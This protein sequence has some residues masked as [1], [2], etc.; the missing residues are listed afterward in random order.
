MQRFWRSAHALLAIAMHTGLPAAIGFGSDTPVASQP[1]RCNPQR[2]FEPSPPWPARRFTWATAKSLNRQCRSGLDVLC[3]VRQQDAAAAP[4]TCHAGLPMPPL[5]LHPS[6]P[7]NRP[8]DAVRPRHA[9]GFR[10]FM[11]QSI[12]ESGLCYNLLQCSVV[13][14]KQHR[15]NDRG[16]FLYCRDRCIYSV[17][18]RVPKGCDP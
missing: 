18:H 7:S 14:G 11:L 16:E 13:N 2:A 9:C 3:A 12:T 15:Q 1:C 8:N 17:V 6:A 10:W 4:R 5:A